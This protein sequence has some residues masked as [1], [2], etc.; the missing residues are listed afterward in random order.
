[1]IIEGG[2]ETST[3]AADL[4]VSS[5]CNDSRSESLSLNFSSPRLGS[6]WFPRDLHWQLQLQ[7]VRLSSLFC[8]RLKP[9]GNLEEYVNGS[10]PG[11]GMI[12]HCRVKAAS[13]IFRWMLTTMGRSRSISMPSGSWSWRS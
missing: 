2:E 4:G 1:M 13:K 3:P 11:P 9:A 10:R 8:R 6:R 12:V 7:D 5:D